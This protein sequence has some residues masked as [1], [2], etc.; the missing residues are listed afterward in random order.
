MEIISFSDF[1]VLKLAQG[2][3]QRRVFGGLR[4]MLSTSRLLRVLIQEAEQVWILVPES[5]LR[6]L[7]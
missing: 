7:F 6:L 2:L 3:A 1:A 4:R 5:L